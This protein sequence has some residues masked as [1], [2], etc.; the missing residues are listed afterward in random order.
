MMAWHHGDDVGRLVGCLVSRYDDTMYLEGA[1][2]DGAAF[3][4]AAVDGAVDGA[5][6]DDTA[7][8]AGVALGTGALGGDAALDCGGRCHPWLTATWPSWRGGA[9]LSGVVALECFDRYEIESFLKVKSKLIESLL[10]YAVKCEQHGLMSKM[11][12]QI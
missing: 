6:I 4:G 8:S 12:W 10:Y 2:L 5:A 1:D 11:F 9:A 3:G 7:L